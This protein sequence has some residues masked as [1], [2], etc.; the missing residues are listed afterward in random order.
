MSN[1]QYPTMEQRITTLVN[2]YFSH[3]VI[4]DEKAAK[5]TLDELIKLSTKSAIIKTLAGMN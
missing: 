3:K 2:T 1:N 4:H 5:D